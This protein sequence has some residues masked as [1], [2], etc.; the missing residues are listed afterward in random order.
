MKD[1]Q[2]FFRKLNSLRGAVNSKRYGDT[3][4]RAITEAAA[5]HVVTAQVLI[6]TVPNENALLESLIESLKG[7]SV[8]KTLR[9]IV[10]PR[11]T[12]ARPGR[13]V[14]AK[15]LFSLGTHAMIECEAGNTEY[16]NVARLI[17]ERLAGLLYSND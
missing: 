4:K 14:C 10:S 1:N 11:S 6:S 9:E 8:Y 2:D 13:N 16:L 7:K 5:G 12:K 3:I 17:H 15:A